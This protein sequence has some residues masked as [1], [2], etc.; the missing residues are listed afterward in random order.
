MS[1][2]KKE[3][4]PF[5]MIPVSMR[6]HLHEFTGAELKL[7]MC[8]YLHSGKDNTAFPS[9]KTIMRE[10]GLSRPGL[11]EAKKGLR[12]KGFSV[13]AFQR[14]RDDGGLSSMTEKIVMPIPRDE[15]HT[16]AE[17]ENIPAQEQN[18]CLSTVQKSYLH[19]VDTSEA[20]TGNLDTGKPQD[21]NQVS[22]LVSEEG[23]SLRSSPIADDK[24]KIKAKPVQVCEQEQEQ[25]RDEEQPELV[26]FIPDTDEDDDEMHNCHGF[27]VTDEQAAFYDPGVHSS[28]LGRDLDREEYLVADDLYFDLLPDRE[29]KE[30]DVVLLAELALEFTAQAVRAAWSFNQRHKNG[31]LKLFGVPD[32]AAALRSDSDRCLLNQMR[33][34]DENIKACEKCEGLK[35]C[36]QCLRVEDMTRSECGRRLDGFY[37]YY[38][39]KGCEIAY[40][41]ERGLQC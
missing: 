4:P 19:E 17:I 14:R 27:R 9:N 18:S 25:H 33:V 12:K 11:K 29:A 36:K 31:K 41:R 7:F 32:L 28:R 30:E 40:A 21:Q 1:N 16:Q 2:K 38:L 24:K 13:A 15:N 26:P 22:E 39:H 10:T 5:K 20:D 8:L 34:H 6:E 23:S 35:C 37:D 3:I